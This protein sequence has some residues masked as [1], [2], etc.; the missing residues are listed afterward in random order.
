MNSTSAWSV[1]EE[2]DNN[3]ERQSQ[4]SGKRKPTSPVDTDISSKR[5][6]DHMSNGTKD[7]VNMHY[8]QSR[9]ETVSG[10]GDSQDTRL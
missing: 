7:N 8:E 3:W 9:A 2:N 6:T 5:Q 4:Y 1:N 10:N